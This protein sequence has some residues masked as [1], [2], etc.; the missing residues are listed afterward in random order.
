MTSART[1]LALPPGY[2]ALVVRAAPRLKDVWHPI[3]HVNHAGG[4]DKLAQV[5]G[6]AAFRV[7]SVRVGCARVVWAR[8]VARPCPVLDA[9]LIR[10]A[11]P[12]DLFALGEYVD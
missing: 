4:M 2:P 10:I 9:L 6:I 5:L 8:L 7:H 3:P 11:V 1:D 12:P